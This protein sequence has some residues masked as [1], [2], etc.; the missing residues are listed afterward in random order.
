MMLDANTWTQGTPLSNL[1]LKTEINTNIAINQRAR[2]GLEGQFLASVLGLYL[3]F[4]LTCAAASPP[5][6]TAPVTGEGWGGERKVVEK[7]S[8]E[9]SSGSQLC[10]AAT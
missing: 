2:G 6:L 10:H 3:C 8:K 4:T 9:G 5:L 7:P 1:G